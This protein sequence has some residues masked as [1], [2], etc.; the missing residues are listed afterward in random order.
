MSNDGP[1]PIATKIDTTG[2]TFELTKLMSSSILLENYKIQEIIV[3][4]SYLMH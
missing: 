2:V 4:H 3:L 1:K